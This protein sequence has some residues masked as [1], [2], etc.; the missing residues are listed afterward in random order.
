MLPIL[1]VTSAEAV[2]GV[3]LIA[4]FM[5]RF[6]AATQVIAMLVAVFLVH[7]SNGLAGEGGYQWVLLLGATAFT[8]MMDGAGRHSVDRMMSNKD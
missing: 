5:T 1:T 7:W 6:A 3:L 8:L 4:G 2:G